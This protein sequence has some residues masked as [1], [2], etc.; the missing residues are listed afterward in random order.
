MGTKIS[1]KCPDG[2]DP[3]REYQDLNTHYRT[4]KHKRAV[5]GTTRPPANGRCPLGC[6]KNRIY[7]GLQAHKRTQMHKFAELLAQEEER[8]KTVH[9]PVAAAKSVRELGPVE[10]KRGVEKCPLGCADGHGYSNLARHKLTKM[11]RKAEAVANTK[12]NT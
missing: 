12:A 3:R 4:E 8:N 5:T 11:H 9:Q 2:C 1:G 10:Q 7:A 6:G